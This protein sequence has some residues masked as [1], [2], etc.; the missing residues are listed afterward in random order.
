MYATGWGVFLTV[1][2]NTLYKDSNVKKKQ[3]LDT[4]IK[5]TNEFEN[6]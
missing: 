2:Q 4:I 6:T 1:A 5:K 3:I